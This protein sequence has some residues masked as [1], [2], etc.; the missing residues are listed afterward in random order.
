MNNTRLNQ[1]IT[2]NETVPVP[3]YLAQLQDAPVVMSPYP[4]A[5]PGPVLPDLAALFPLQQCSH[6]SAEDL[7]DGEVIVAC[8]ECAKLPSPRDALL[9]YVAAAEVHEYFARQFTSQVPFHLGWVTPGDIGRC[10]LSRLLI[11]YLTQLD[12]AAFH[13]WTERFLRAVATPAAQVACGE[14]PSPHSTAEELALHFILCTAE[15]WS[16]EEVEHPWGSVA[17]SLQQYPQDHR[18]RYSETWFEDLD[19][20]ELYDEG[21]WSLNLSALDNNDLNPRNWFRPFH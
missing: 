10:G 5:S 4:Q 16:R 12:E 9:I 8:G 13:D 15:R 20:T 7:E 11:D 3:Q 19:V 18:W 6:L 1:W 2:S 17:A 21:L 14:P